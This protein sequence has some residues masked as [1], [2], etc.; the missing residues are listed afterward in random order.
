MKPAADRIVL[1]SVA[2][3]ASVAL[4]ACGGPGALEHGVV[5][6]KRGHAAYTTTEYR[7]VYRETNC[8]NITTSAFT[9]S[10]V[11]K[12]GAGGSRSGSGSSRGGGGK[13]S[14]PTAPDLKKTDGKTGKEGTGGTRR[15]CDRTLERREPYLQNHPAS[16]ELELE[17][18]GRT[19]WKPVFKE[20]W[21]EIKIGDRV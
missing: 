8:R 1:A 12:P 18:G 4:T 19:G 7:N 20:T 9:L 10:A 6:D 17:D 21:D 15:V 11:S 5:K 16:W 13:G 2:I 14:Q 3:A